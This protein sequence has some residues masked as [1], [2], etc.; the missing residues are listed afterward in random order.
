MSATHR[1]RLPR[2]TRSEGDRGR[3]CRKAKARAD[4]QH[5]VEEELAGFAADELAE[6]VEGDGE[7]G[8]F[9]GERWER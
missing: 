9:E 6:A 8:V 7:G 2:R 5:G 4:L 3:R 1:P